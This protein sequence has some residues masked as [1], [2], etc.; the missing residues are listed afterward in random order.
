MLKVDKEKLI[1]E[2]KKD[3]TND[4][5][6]SILITNPSENEFKMLVKIKCS[7]TEV[8]RVSQSTLLLKINQS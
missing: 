3:Q 8:F 2:L 5:S 7:N 4:V 1:Y 6:D